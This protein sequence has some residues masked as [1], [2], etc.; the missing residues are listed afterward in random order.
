MKK[1]SKL[2]LIGV[3]LMLFSNLYYLVTNSFDAW[4]FGW[5]HTLG[6]FWNILNLAAWV[7]IGQFFYQLYKKSK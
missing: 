7:L 3:G 5:Y 1:S 4:Q 2:A 6:H